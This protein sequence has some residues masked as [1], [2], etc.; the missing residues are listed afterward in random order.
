[1]NGTKFSG[2]SVE[3]SSNDIHALPP[4]HHIRHSYQHACKL[5][6]TETAHVY[7]VLP[8]RRICRHVC[9]LHHTS[10][11]VCYNCTITGMLGTH[12]LDQCACLLYLYQTS[13][14]TIIATGSVYILTISM[15]HT[16][17]M[18]VSYV[19]SYQHP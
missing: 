5:C 9:L 4:G 11:N 6:G 15:L 13:N 19:S 2:I 1:M 17:S 8:R 14:P 10:N 7:A 3:V 18:H 16:I 12:V